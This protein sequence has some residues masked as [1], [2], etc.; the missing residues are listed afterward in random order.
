MSTEAATAM[1][2]IIDGFYTHRAVHAMSARP[3]GSI[4]AYAPGSAPH[5]IL[6]AADQ[7]DERIV[8]RRHVVAGVARAANFRRRRGR[9]SHRRVPRA[10]R[11]LPSR[12]RADRI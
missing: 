5:E 6:Y 7:R 11:P 9:T 10:P 2:P 4:G 12:C 8:A 3:R 1:N